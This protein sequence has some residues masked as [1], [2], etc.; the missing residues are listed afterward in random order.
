MHAHVRGVP[1]AAE[2]SKVLVGARAARSYIEALNNVIMVVV[3]DGEVER[4]L[5]GCC[6][7]RSSVVCA[8][9]VHTAIGPQLQVAGVVGDHKLVLGQTVHTTPLVT[10][11]GEH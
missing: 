4:L 9:R 2:D 1:A 10:G 3:F 8:G 11:E 7:A 5:V 6:I